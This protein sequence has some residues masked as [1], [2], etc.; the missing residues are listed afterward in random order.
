MAKDLKEV[1]PDIFHGL[2]TWHLM[3]NGIKHLGNLMKDGSHFLTD[4]KRC[5]YGIGDET[6]FEEAWI[7]L[8]AQYNIHE[9]TWLQSTYSIKE[10]WAACYTKKAFTLGMR[11]TQLSESINFDIKM[12]I[13]PDLDIMQFFKHFEQVL[14]NK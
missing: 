3:Q 7:V 8:L 9:N 5:M 6:Q 4:F 1:M 14:Q 13:K 10:K 2:C 11:S 12:C